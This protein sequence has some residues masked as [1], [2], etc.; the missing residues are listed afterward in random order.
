MR[1]GYYKKGV[2]H[3]N[4][5]KL[6][7]KIDSNKTFLAYEGSMHE[8]LEHGIGK[9]FYP[10]G[11]LFYEGGYYQ[12]HRC[13]PNGKIYFEKGNIKFKGGFKQSLYHG[14]GF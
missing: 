1:E 11:K 3:G 5:A 4:W 12:G 9:E 14:N 2:I 13:C 8:G 10:S 7:E 6:Y